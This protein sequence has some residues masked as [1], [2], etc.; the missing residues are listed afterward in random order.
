LNYF[1]KWSPEKHYEIDKK[2]TDYKSEPDGRSERTDTD[3]ANLDDKSNGFHY[4]ITLVKFGI[5]RTTLDISHQIRDKIITWYECADLVL[6][7]DYEYLKNMKKNFLNIL[8]LINEN[9]II[10]KF[11]I[12]LIWKKDNDKWSSKHVVKK[13]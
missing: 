12:K 11:R 10:D 6:Q 13:L 2:Y 1:T 5:G 3:Y 4:Y 8:E 9:Q 7:Y